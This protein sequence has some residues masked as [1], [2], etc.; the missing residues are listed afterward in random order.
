MKNVALCAACGALLVGCAC[1]V[2]VNDFL[3]AIQPLA[4]DN[5]HGPI[6]ARAIGPAPPLDD[7]A[8][9]SQSAS[10][11]FIIP[12]AL[13]PSKGGPRPGGTSS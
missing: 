11:S 10:F 12:L 2:C 4:F 6:K 1:I 8:R 13:V 9:A 3:E 7:D 5:D